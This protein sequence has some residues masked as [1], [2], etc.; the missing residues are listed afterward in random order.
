MSGPALVRPRWLKTRIPSGE[1]YANV[2]RIIKSHRLHTVCQEASCPNV[3][4]CW[5]AGTATIMIMGDICTRGCGFC[6]VNTGRSGSL[7]LR[8]PSAVAVAIRDL[9]LRY[10]VITSVCR[11]DLPDSGA[12]H[13]AE[14]IRH[15]RHRCPNTI[16]ESLIPDFAGDH[17]LIDAV[18]DAGP[19]VVGHNIETVRR[20]TRQ[21]RDRRA[22]YSQSLQVLRHTKEGHPGIFTKS[23][24]MLGLGEST[25]EILEAAIDLRE[26]MVDFVALGQYMQPSTRHLP[27]K[28]YIHPERF[29]QIKHMLSDLGFLHV[30][31]GPFVRSSFRASDIADIVSGH[32]GM[33]PTT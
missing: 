12:G 26:S 32:R 31:A 8:E 3:A 30:N 29:D 14:T 5:G 2:R 24:M 23:S 6:D 21:V 28:E 13:F 25:D 19:H 16:V 10:A 18:A 22:G 33:R 11:D 15:I 17:T 4:E 9:G 1:A 7:D 20:L 27:V